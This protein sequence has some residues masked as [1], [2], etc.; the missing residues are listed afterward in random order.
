MFDPSMMFEVVKWTDRI[1]LMEIHFLWAQEE[2]GR[3]K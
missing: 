3:S 1:D 2:G